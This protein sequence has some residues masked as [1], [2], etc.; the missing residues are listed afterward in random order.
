VKKLLFVIDSFMVGGVS[1][2]LLNLLQEIHLDYDIEVLSFS[3]DGQ[4]HN[5]CPNRVRQIKST[6][7]LS[8]LGKSQS[9]V[10]RESIVLGLF[11]AALVIFT[12][13]FTNKLPHRFLYKFSPSLS[14]RYDIA[15]SYIHD[16][17]EFALSRGC[18]RFV[19]EKVNSKKKIAFVHCDFEKYGGNTDRNKEIYRY[20][21][22]IV[23]VSKGCKLSFQRANPNL[24]TV[25]N[26]RN[27]I[28]VA[29]IQKKAQICPL[30]CTSEINLVTVSRMSYEKG[31]ARAIQALICIINEGISIPSFRWY[32]VGGGPQLEELKSL[33]TEGGLGGVVEFVGN[34]DN[35]YR[36]MQG[37]QYF[38]LPSYHECAP[39]V[40]DEANVLGLTILTTETLSTDEMIMEP[41]CGYVFENSNH[42]L[43][44]MFRK[45]LQGQLPLKRYSFLDSNHRLKDCIEKLFKD[46]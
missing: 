13:I 16:H 10:T 11:R 35:P 39:M 3:S 33:V 37:C 23:C 5:Q 15:I 14:Q 19:I 18:N 2:A 30:S 40:F 43:N 28:N 8:L 21:D 20:F 17:S 41:D 6:K 29:E 9:E 12:K 46:S 45:L 4:L 26:I 44:L 31:I 25:V 7:L 1:R 22:N 36:I 32:L 34:T 38:L 42:G 24:S 27:F